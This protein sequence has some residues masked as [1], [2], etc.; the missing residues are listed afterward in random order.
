[1]QIT[2]SGHHVDV[3][4]SLR[5]HAKSKLRKVA[6]HFSEVVA[7]NVTLILGNAKNHTTEINTTYHGK[8]V[9]VRVEGTDMYAAITQGR[10][11]LHRILADLK[12]AEKAARKDKPIPSEHLEPRVEDGA[13]S[14]ARIA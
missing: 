12:G 10:D 8:D 6:S 13:Q 5:D 11:K 2:V 1:M 4:D 14:A 7:I 3:T 9:A